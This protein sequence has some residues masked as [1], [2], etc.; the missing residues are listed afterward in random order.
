VKKDAVKTG[1]PEDKLLNYYKS[2]NFA[3][4]LKDQKLFDFLKVNNKIN[5]MDPETY[6]NKLKTEG[7]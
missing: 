7:N 6:N 1:L 4:R 2:S 3:D 5:K